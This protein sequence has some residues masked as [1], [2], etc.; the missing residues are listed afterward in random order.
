VE[1]VKRHLKSLGLV[2]VGFV[3]AMI[4]M[5]N[6]AGWHTPGSAAKLVATEKNVAVANALAPLCAEK[7]LAQADVETKRTALANASS[8]ARRDMF[9]EKWVTLPGQSSR[10]TNLVEACT[11][12]VLKQKKV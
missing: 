5:P 1:N 3:L 11:A 2:A 8:W 12:L 10:D 7:F 4:V 6:F 9:P